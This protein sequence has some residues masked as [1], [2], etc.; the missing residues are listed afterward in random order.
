MSNS[1]SPL[2]LA[3]QVTP[4]YLQRCESQYLHHH[5]TILSWNN[6]YFSDYGVNNAADYWA[7]LTKIHSAQI[8]LQSVHNPAQ[9]LTFQQLDES[10]NLYAKYFEAQLP[11]PN[12]KAPNS[13][14]SENTAENDR[15]IN[16]DSKT[17]FTV[18]LLMENCPHFIILWLSLAKLG[19]TVALLNHNL[20]PEQ[21][22][23]AI[24]TAK[25]KAI[26]TSK[27]FKQLLEQTKQ[28]KAQTNVIEPAFDQ[29]FISAADEN[30]NIANSSDTTS[31]S[32][33]NE[34]SSD[35][36]LSDPSIEQFVSKIHLDSSVDYYSHFSQYRAYIHL[37]SP[38]F[39]INTSGTTGR[40]KAAYFSHRRFIGAGITWSSAMKL[41]PQD[42]YYISLPLYHGN[43]GCVAISACFH[44]GCAAIIREK[45]SA[46]QFWREISQLQCTAMIYVGEL[47][48]Y[49]SNLA[50]NPLE[51][52][53]RLRVI[54]GNGLRSEIWP[55]ITGRF[56]VQ[57]VV[58]H[59]GMTE[60]PA[61][62]YINFYNRAGACGFIPKSVRK[63]QNADKLIEFD[64][65]NNK[66][67]RRT[68][69]H[70]FCVEITEPDTPGECIFLLAR[71]VEY[72]ETQPNAE[73]PHVPND[74]KVT[75]KISSENQ[76]NISETKQNH[77]S[78]SLEKCKNPWYK[79]YCGYSDYSANS[80]KVY[81]S[82][83][84]REDAWFSTGDL[85][86]TDRDGFIYF[87][88]R[89]GDSLRYKGENIATVEVEN[90]VNHEIDAVAESNCYGVR[91]TG[92]EGKFS[93][94]A[95]KLKPQLSAESLDFAE[96][97]S[98]LR[99]KLA[100]L[101]L[102]IFVRIVGQT[103]E[104]SKTSTLKLQKFFLQQ[105]GIALEEGKKEFYVV[106]HEKK[107]YKLLTKEEWKEIQQ[108]GY[109]QF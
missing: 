47:W 80:S 40:P 27:K 1:L 71:G 75:D 65:I 96:F 18:C 90:A 19:Y 13:E 34:N 102:P 23:Y 61:G 93:C 79:P 43:A 15:N 21:L 77:N 98:L 25:A 17:R 57:H 78:Q 10:S 106:D 32:G 55:L 6:K 86:S 89:A 60:M 44:T 28:L 26:I 24:Q 29:I 73:N 66:P 109:R 64:V 62:P 38:L 7:V 108:P 20:Q 45:F 9:S 63:L 58:E 5:A 69:N 3:D 87:V 103:Q 51:K 14:N 37:D 41:L 99:S 56:A 94:V 12:N 97:Y 82:V 48:R 39:Y 105:Q 46:S 107:S 101:A 104:L 33:N 50:E 95:I 92:K 84:E 35:N 70:G 100:L 81:R 31:S 8:C 83:F 22:L 16:V 2:I 54:A 52:A 91:I 53:H 85:L 4:Q 68:E 88:D 49:L 72:Y 74:I 76:A 59:Y 30:A 42:R 67:V 11:L 36:S